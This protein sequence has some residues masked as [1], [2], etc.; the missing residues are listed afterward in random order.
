[1]LDIFMGYLVIFILLLGG[2]ISLFL[3]EFNVSKIK[4][5]FIISILSI[6]LFVIFLSSNYLANYLLFLN[7]YFG[8]LFVVI[9][10]ILLIIDYIYLKYGKSY[11]FILG[12]SFLFLVMILSLSSQMRGISI[13]DSLGLTVFLFI[14]LI[15]LYPISSLLHYAR[16]DYFVVV[17]EFLSIEIVLFILLGL[18]YCS[19]RDLD[20]SLFNSF[21]ILTP[22]YQL[23]YVFVVMIVILL[24]GLYYNDKQ[25]KK[26]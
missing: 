23:V 15:L 20:Y 24:I 6:L 8:F 14:F 25:L 11:I 1:M 12:V 19:L 17:G 16:R 2:T 10:I 4:Y 18:T 9:A 21:L 22:T 26:R 7:N 5:M 3:N 13:L